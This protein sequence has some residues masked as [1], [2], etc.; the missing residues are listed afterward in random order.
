MKVFVPFDEQHTLP[1][2]EQAESVEL[3]PF[4]LE[5]ACFRAFRTV[6]RGGGAGA[7][8]CQPLVPPDGELTL[9][10]G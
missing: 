9:Q 6:E 1:L 3:V 8:W 2:A 5:Y 4:R 7:S 10:T